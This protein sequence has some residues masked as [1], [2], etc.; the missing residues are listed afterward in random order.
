[1][2]E[3]NSNPS[4]E[5][6]QEHEAVEDTNP[7]HLGEED[8]LT[9]EPAASH[10]WLEQF[11]AFGHAAWAELESVAGQG[12]QEAESDI[13]IALAVKLINLAKE[14][15]PAAESKFLTSLHN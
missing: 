11:Q 8:S 6:N 1:M 15:D 10:G 9:S 14:H 5:N 13:L 4:D 7:E 3:D 12:L 2:S